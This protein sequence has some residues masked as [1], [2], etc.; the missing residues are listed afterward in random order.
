VQAWVRPQR[1]RLVVHAVLMLSIAALALVA[2]IF[3][4]WQPPVL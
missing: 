2:V 1:T 4:A 3:I